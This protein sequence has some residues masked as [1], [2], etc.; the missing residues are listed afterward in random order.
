M[1]YLTFNPNFNY[2]KNSATKS[3]C[4]QINQLY[5]FYSFV[6]SFSN[7]NKTFLGSRQSK[8]E[9]PA[10]TNCKIS[11]CIDRCCTE[12]FVFCLPYNSLWRLI[13]GWKIA[14][15]LSARVSNIANVSFLK[16][17]RGHAF[18]RHLNDINFIA[19][20]SNRNKTIF[21]LSRLLGIV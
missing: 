18:S 17:R 12:K 19:S 20:F 2:K 14:L 21:Y 11:P 4:F 3:D 10:E 1:F 9:R 7:P 5:Y 15:S 16:A 13:L 8:H 6:A